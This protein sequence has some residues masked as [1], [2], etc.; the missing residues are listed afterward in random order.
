MYTITLY[1]QIQNK[2]AVQFYM[3]NGFE[4]KETL[5]DYY[6]DLEDKGA[7]YCE[8]KPIVE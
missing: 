5:E 2:H 3:K 7:Y 4:I 6:E 1:V 8:Y